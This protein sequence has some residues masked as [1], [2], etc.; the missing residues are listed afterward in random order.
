MPLDVANESERRLGDV[1]LDVFVG[2][3]DADRL[4]GDPGGVK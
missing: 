3:T 4:G 2:D 1:G